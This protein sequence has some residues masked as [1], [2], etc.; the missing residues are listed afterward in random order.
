MDGTLSNLKDTHILMRPWYKMLIVASLAT[1]VALVFLYPAL[2]QGEDPPTGQTLSPYWHPNV[3]RWEHVIVPYSQDRNLD[4]DL[5]AAVIWKESLGNSTA[6]GPTGAVGL[7]GL[8][9]FA[10]RPSPEKL[11]LP[12]VNLFWGARALAHTIRDGKGDVYY[13]LAAY[14]GGWD[15]IHL[16]VTRRYAADVLGH[17]TRAVAVRYGLPA[18]GNWIAILAIEGTPGPNTVTVLGPQRPLTRYTERP[19]VRADIP[20]VPVGFPP[21]S[22]TIVFVDERGVEGRVNLW[23]VAED[24]SLLEGTTASPVFSSHPLAAGATR[25][26]QVDPGVRVGSLD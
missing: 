21:H 1:I 4:P 16:R 18:D 2:A 26:E 3:I 14:N 22:T 24:G 13:A 17:Y 8:K 11:E 9:P 12:W 6:R 23:L 25:D 20:S 19:W 7:M 15:Q 10:W 5:V